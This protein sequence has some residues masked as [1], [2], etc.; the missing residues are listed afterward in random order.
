MAVQ[1]DLVIF[2]SRLMNKTIIDN[3]I[4]ILT[5]KSTSPYLGINSNLKHSSWRR[6]KRWALGRS[7]VSRSVFSSTIPN[8]NCQRKMKL[9]GLYY[10]KMSCYYQVTIMNKPS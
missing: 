2:M 10:K 7:L 1:L 3:Q 5:K 4:H 9:E 6:L 8:K